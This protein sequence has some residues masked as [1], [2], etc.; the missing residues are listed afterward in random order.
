[1]TRPFRLAFVG[2]CLAFVFLSGPATAESSLTLGGE[3]VAEITRTFLRHHYS[4]L[5]FGDEQSRQLLKN[6]M[7]RLDRGHYY[8]L[9]SDVDNFQ[10]Y[11]TRLDDLVRRKNIE[12]A[13]EIFGRLRTRLTERGVMIDRLLDGKFDLRS[14]DSTVLDRSEEPYPAD[15]ADAERLWAKRLKFELLQR[16]LGGAK[17]EEAKQS[18]RRRYR[19]RRLELQ[20]YSRNDVVAEFLNS[21]TAVYD[22]HSSYLSPDRRENFDISLRLS[23]EGIG[24]TLRWEDGLTV[25]A[26]IIAGGAA[27]REG[28]LK[29][30]DRIVSVAQGRNGRFEGVRDMRLIEVVKK[31]RGPKGTTVRLLVLRKGDGPVEDR[32]EI[33]IVRDKINLTEAEAKAR[34]IETKAAAGVPPYRIGLI[35]LPSFY[36][37]FSRRNAHPRDYKSSSR[38]VKKI[39]KK[40]QGENIDGVLL[41]LRNNG[42]GGL[43]EA[44]TLSGLFLPRG[45]VVLVKDLRG[46]LQRYR[47]PRRQPLYKGPL[48]VLT[49]RYSASASEILAGALKDYGRAV[50]VGDRSTFGKGT[51]Q[52]IIALPPGL[53][54]LKTTVAKFYRP[55]SS[56]TQNRGVV[57]DIVL[58]SL[59]NHLEI[60]ESSLDNALPWEAIAPTGFTPWGDLSP[61]LP[62]LAE[63]S[64]LRRQGKPRFQEIE[65]RVAEYLAQEK[66]RKVVTVSQ[67]IER[68][69]K[70]KKNGP[71]KAAATPPPAQPADEDAYLLEVV[72][73]LVDYIELSAKKGGPRVVIRKR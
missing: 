9:Q 51:V 30:D 49:N 43:D 56:S 7:R 55:G 48:V 11:S 35:T 73:I 10:Q 15:A 45:P 2:A 44:V 20:R 1:M 41:D 63:R 42:G 29:P 13:H 70:G 36:V 46:R 66:N 14:E 12:I 50:L 60:G 65:R 18:L 59:N 57:P 24:A 4:G 38:D 21:F 31:I 67:L 53:G 27:F 5:T 47:N 19:S 64:R 61:V 40:F 33:A 26:T 32:V 39:L 37:D 69:K 23:F 54:A 58:P 52:N 8:F 68:S 6:F 71:S 72:D 16:V 28:N 22:P 3:Q 25:V 62:V 17:E 34:V